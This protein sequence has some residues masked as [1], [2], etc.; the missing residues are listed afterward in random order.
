MINV[1]VNG[2]PREVPS[3]ATVLGLLNF[4]DLAPEG[5]AVA[6]NGRVVPRTEHSK[7]RVRAG[8]RVEIV[9]AVGGG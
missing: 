7:L 4:V 1:E 2:E 8:D 5:V 3:G 9:R 6:V